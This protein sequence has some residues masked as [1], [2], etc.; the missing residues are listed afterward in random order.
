MIGLYSNI[1]TE[2]DVGYIYWM[3]VL[4]F[5]SFIVWLEIALLIL[6]FF[7]KYITHSSRYYFPRYYDF[8]CMQLE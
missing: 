2:L 6:I 1:H 4:L 3:L 5:L 8:Q 7:V